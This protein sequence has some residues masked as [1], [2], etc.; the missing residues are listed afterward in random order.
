MQTT[1][2]FD[3]KK[4]VNI[5]TILGLITLIILILNLAM[6]RRDAEYKALCDRVKRLESQ[7]EKIDMKFE[8]IYQLLLSMKNGG[9]K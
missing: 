3:Y 6:G 1:K 4:Y 5:N 2:N 8:N 9:K 7:Y